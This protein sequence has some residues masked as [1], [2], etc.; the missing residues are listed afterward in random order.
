MIKQ[1]KA[2]TVNMVAGANVATVVV[3][4]MVGYADHVNPVSHPV[5]S[6]LGLTFRF[7]L[8][9]TCFFFSSGLPSSAA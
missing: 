1:L 7:F 6:C 2:F 3:M 4:L 9:S 5:L 8:S